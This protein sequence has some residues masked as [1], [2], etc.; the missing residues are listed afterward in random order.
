MS[1]SCNLMSHPYSLGNT[2]E[3]TN[4][5]LN[6]NKIFKHPIVII[7]CVSNISS[8][9][10]NKTLFSETNSAVIYNFYFITSCSFVVNRRVV[11]PHPTMRLRSI[12]NE[13]GWVVEKILPVSFLATA[14]RHNK[15]FSRKNSVINVAENG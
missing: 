10:R 4:R 7:E 5:A 9:K 11:C 1:Q 12:R 15:C 13:L 14:K 3:M 6:I 8:H 2:N